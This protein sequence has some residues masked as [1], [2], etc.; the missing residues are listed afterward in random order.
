MDL[1]ESGIIEFFDGTHID[2]SR[3][4][5][6]SPVR[7]PSEG[8]GSFVYASFEI[9]YM[10]QEK[11]RTFGYQDTD[12]LCQDERQAI[13]KKHY[14]AAQAYGG[15]NDYQMARGEMREKTIEALETH[16]TALVEAWEAFKLRH[17]PAS[18]PKVSA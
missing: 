8:L 9:L 15:K 17:P 6:V 4:L 13:F 12:F 2:L 14:D 11:A 7:S 3:I 10:F 18:I 5:E 1:S 16:R